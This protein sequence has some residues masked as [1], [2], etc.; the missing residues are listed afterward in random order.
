MKII[1]ITIIIFLFL[2]NISLAASVDLLNNHE[3]EHLKNEKSS[4][5]I[6]HEHE[7]G[8]RSDLFHD[9]YYSEPWRLAEE[10]VNLTKKICFLILI[11]L[12]LIVYIKRR[13][14]RIV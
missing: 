8:E 5:C 7:Q 4:T 14:K 2:I 11:N 13:F 9:E 3:H 12:F 10:K 6:T 1:N